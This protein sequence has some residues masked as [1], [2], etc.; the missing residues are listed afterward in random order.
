M[1]ALDGSRSSRLGCNS[2]YQDDSIYVRARIAAPS[3]FGPFFFLCDMISF[4]IFSRSGKKREA[5][6]GEAVRDGSVG[7]THLTIVTSAVSIC[8]ALFN[9][10]CWRRRWLSQYFLCLFVG[11]NLLMSDFIEQKSLLLLRHCLFRTIP[12]FLKNKNKSDVQFERKTCFQKS[13]SSFEEG[14]EYPVL[15]RKL[16]ITLKNEIITTRYRKTGCDQI[17]GYDDDSS[18]MITCAIL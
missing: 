6:E 18:Y 2:I 7:V 11:F 1:V 12:F 13:R 8:A 16:F 5:T 17:T 3:S 10:I 14:K 9:F 4:N 15:L